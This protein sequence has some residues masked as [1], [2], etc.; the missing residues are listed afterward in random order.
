MNRVKDEGK[1]AQKN[2]FHGN[3]AMTFC[4]QSLSLMLVKRES[5]VNFASLWYTD[6]QINKIP[7]QNE[8]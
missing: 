4:I 2:F 5:V 1:N 8:P 3:E 6:T 7:A